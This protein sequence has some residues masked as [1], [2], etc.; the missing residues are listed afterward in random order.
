MKTLLLQLD[1][2]RHPSAFDRIVA[3]DAGAHDVLSYGGV[4]PGDVTALVHGAI[5]TRGPDD[6][7][8]TAIWIGG[9][10]VT[11][12]EEML[13]TAVAAFF[14]PLRVSVMMDSNG[15]NTTAAATV[16]AIAKEQPLAGARAVVLAGTGPVGLRVA[17]LLARESARVTLVP[18]WPELLGDRWDV[19]RST[20]EKAQAETAGAKSGFAVKPAASPAERRQA[21]AEATIA[22]SAGPLGANVLSEEDWAS[23]GTLRVLV[24]L[25]PVN[26]VGIAG[27]KAGDA[28]KARN[29]RVVFGALG[30][31]GLK[32]KVHK[33]A[34]AKLFQARD[35]VLDAAS[36]YELAR[37]VI[38]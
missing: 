34:V 28:A 36:I 12:G 25:N 29:D 30:L 16:A 23:H 37:A 6:L 19:G 3:Y 35:Q 11:V 5:F 7:H 18:A 32:M 15:C 21:L 4:T 20:R 31:G 9:S 33:A 14:G 24:D 38:A 10:S 26:P 1:S 27:V 17:E 8:R 2:D 22:V 13:K